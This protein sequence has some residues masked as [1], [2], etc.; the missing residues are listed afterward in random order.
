MRL[1][2]SKQNHVLGSIL[3]ELGT[4]TQDQLDEALRCQASGDPRPLGAILMSLGHLTAA[5]VEHALMMQ[6]ARRGHL[7]QEEGLNLIHRAV[8]CTQKAVGEIE[9][10][11]L[12]AEEFATKAKE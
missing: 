5:E 4:V 6:K 2:R 12:A 7:S 1:F 8:Q 9:E 3:I 11:T 10:L